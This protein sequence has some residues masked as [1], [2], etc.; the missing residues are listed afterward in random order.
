MLAS[1]FVH[2]DRKKPRIRPF[3]AM[4]HMRALIADKEDT[5][6]V[7]HIIEALNGSA[8]LKDLERFAHTPGGKARLSERRSLAPILDE[9]RNDLKKYPEGTVGKTYACLLYTSPSPRDA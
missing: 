7:F 6:Q 8:L 4:K 9:M 1:P 2:P 5:E 3:K